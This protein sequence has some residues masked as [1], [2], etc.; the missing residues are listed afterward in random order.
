[1][2][3]VHAYERTCGMAN[4]TCAERDEDAPVHVVI[5]MAGNVY[6]PDW[7][8]FLPESPPLDYTGNHHQQPPW[9]I[10]RTM[11]F[12]YTRIHT[13]ATSLH[14]RLFGDQRHQVHDEFYLF[15]KAQ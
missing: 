2:A 7:Q 13:N 10:F 8:A 4:F 6:N 12:G 9:S 15:K 11:D 3:Q 14:F 5:G 1:M